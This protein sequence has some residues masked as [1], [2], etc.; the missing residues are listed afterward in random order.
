[1]I[2]FPSNKYKM[3][4]HSLIVEAGVVGATL[5]PVYGAVC[6]SVNAL[7]GATYDKE[8]K[9]GMWMVKI[10]LT[11]F[12]YHGLAEFYGMN[13]WFLRASVAKRKEERRLTE[14][15]MSRRETRYNY[16][17]YAVPQFPDKDRRQPLND[18]WTQGSWTSSPNG[19]IQEAVQF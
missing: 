12:I 10:A 19:I 6:Q 8:D 18:K 14:D 15:M 7:T 9:S 1:L 4:G 5:I 11:G 3:P 13:D 16:S 17:N 2:D